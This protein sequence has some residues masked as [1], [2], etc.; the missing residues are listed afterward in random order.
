MYDILSMSHKIVTHDQHRRLHP[1]SPAALRLL[2]YS[3]NVRACAHFST[4]RI[5]STPG[6]KLQGSKS[7]GS[8][9]ELSRIDSKHF[10]T[11]LYFLSSE[12]AGDRCSLNWHLRLVLIHS[13]LVATR[14]VATV[15]RE[16]GEETSGHSAI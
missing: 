15:W 12:Q 6:N 14:K 10:Y 1:H 3:I 13:S 16:L 4:S 8:K 5:S 9:H 7:Q 2:S 11:E